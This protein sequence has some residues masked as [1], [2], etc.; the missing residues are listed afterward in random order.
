MEQSKNS[1]SVDELLARTEPSRA[2]D[3]TGSYDPGFFEKFDTP[4]AMRHLADARIGL[5]LFIDEASA[6][7]A[8]DDLTIDQRLHVAQILSYIDALASKFD[9]VREPGFVHKKR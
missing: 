6:A 9:G 8:T 1:V 3:S 7:L 2:G 5:A 4:A